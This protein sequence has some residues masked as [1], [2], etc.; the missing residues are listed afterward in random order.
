[1]EDFQ[2]DELNQDELEL[3]LSAFGYS[4]DHEGYIVD[5]LLNERV[6]SKTTNNWL[7]ATDAALMPGSLKII[8]SDPVAVSKYLREQ[9]GC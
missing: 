9:I 4:T 1:M 5:R 8:D 3:L 6:R 7:K 2:F